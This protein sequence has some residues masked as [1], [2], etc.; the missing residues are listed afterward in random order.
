MIALQNN[1]MNTPKLTLVPIERCLSNYKI[2]DA[3]KNMKDYP[4]GGKKII[5]Q[6][7]LPIG[8]PRLIHTHWMIKEKE[9]YRVEYTYIEVKKMKSKYY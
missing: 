8:N 3:E 6:I 4:I 9:G 5:Y 7:A 2:N 1:K